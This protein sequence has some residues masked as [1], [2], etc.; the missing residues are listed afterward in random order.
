MLNNINDDCLIATSK[1]TSLE[2][3]LSDCAYVFKRVSKTATI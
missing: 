2:C 1:S 3:V